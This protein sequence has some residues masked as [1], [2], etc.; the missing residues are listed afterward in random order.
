MQKTDRFNYAQDYV[1]HGYKELSFPATANNGFAL[2]QHALH[3]WPRGNFMLI[4]LPNLDGSFTVTLFLP[5]EGEI[6]FDRLNSKVAVEAFFEEHFSDT[7]PLM[8]NLYKEFQSNPT[9]SLVTIKSFPWVHNNT[10]ILGDA[11]HAIVPFY[12]QG[13]NAGFEDC[14][15]L[16]KLIDTHQENWPNMLD[17]FQNR[18]KPDADAIADLALQNFVEM[19]DK[20]GNEQFLLRKK[21]EARLQE[22][23]PEQWIPQYSMVTFN[24]NVRYSEALA[25]GE[26]Q[27]KIMDEVMKQKEIASTWQSMDLQF[28]IDQLSH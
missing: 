14:F 3:I 4:A 22:Q 20:V 6:S 10:T 25:K 17:A 19:R 2:E 8:P 24:E 23:Y 26:R 28:I 9:A 11:A 1:P 15:E 18:R 13:M 16:N 7:I 21:I 5:F 12:G 27:N